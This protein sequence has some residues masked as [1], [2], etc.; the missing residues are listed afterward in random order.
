MSFI[1][2]S[3]YQPFRILRKEKKLAKA[4]KFFYFQYSLFKALD[5]LEK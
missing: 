1:A 3:K 2:T 5:A 4:M